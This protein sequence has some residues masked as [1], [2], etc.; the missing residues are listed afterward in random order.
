MNEVGRFPDPPSE[1]GCPYGFCQAA[2][3]GSSAGL[4]GWYGVLV[5][6]MACRTSTRRR[7]RQMRAALCFLPSARF[8]S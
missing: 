6:S 1:G 4:V 8:R 7:A 2:R 5:R 3:R